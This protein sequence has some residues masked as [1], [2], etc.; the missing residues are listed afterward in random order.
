MNYDKEIME[1][2]EKTMDWV[3]YGGHHFENIYSKFF[4]IIFTKEIWN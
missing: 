4:I 1:E 2:I 3:D